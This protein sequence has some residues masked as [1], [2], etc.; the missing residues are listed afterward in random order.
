MVFLEGGT[1]KPAGKTSFLSGQDCFLERNILFSGSNLKIE[2]QNTHSLAS[3]RLFNGSILEI[4]P[5]IICP[6][7]WKKSWNGSKIKIEPLMIRI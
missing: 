1:V 6:L 3:G 2:P 4:E 7:T 5:L